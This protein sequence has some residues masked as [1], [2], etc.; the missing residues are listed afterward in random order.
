[1]T[2]GTT[3]ADLARATLEGVAYQVAD[4]VEAAE[5]DLG[6]R[7]PA[8]RV[9]GGM[10]RNDTFLA[11][12]ADVLGLPVLAAPHPEMTALGAAFLAAVGAGL[13]D[14]ATLAR[15]VQPPRRFEPTASA[16][17]RRRRLEALAGRGQGRRCVGKPVIDHDSERRARRS[18]VG[19]QINAVRIKAERPRSAAA[20][21]RRV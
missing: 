6:E 4:L 9:D 13:T 21:H 5:A 10:A 20:G 11:W 16:D 12:Q 1:M 7:L 15:R 2:R 14:E 3:A 17:D 19:T 8:L 18:S